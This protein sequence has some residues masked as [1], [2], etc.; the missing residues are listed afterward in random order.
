MW[1]CGTPAALAP[2]TFVHRRAW[3]LRWLSHHAGPLHVGPIR[4]PCGRIDIPRDLQLHR[5]VAVVLA[6]AHLL[7]HARPPSAQ[8]KPR[9]TAELCSFT[10]CPP[11]AYRSAF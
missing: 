11:L 2:V 6:P 7:P 9:H 3:P 8:E 1:A 10:D 4:S 5:P